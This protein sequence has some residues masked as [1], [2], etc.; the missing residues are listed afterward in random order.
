MKLDITKNSEVK[1]IWM[2]SDTHLG[3]RS[4]SKE[5]LGLVENYFFNFFI[6]LVKREYKVGDILIHCGDVFDSRHSINLFVQDLGIRI[7]EE[8]SSIFPFIYVIVGN[9][10]IAMKQ[11]N[12][13]SSVD[14]LKYI[15]GV[16]IL[17]N[18]EE[19]VFGNTRCLL[20]PWRRDQQHELETVEKFPN[21]KYVFCHSEVSGLQMSSNPKNVVEHGNSV[22]LYKKYK[23]VFS[24]HIHYHQR[25]SNF[26]LVGNPY[27]MTRSDAYNRKGIY[28]L[29]LETE[30]LDFFENNYSPK[31]LKVNF[32]NIQEIA[33][34]AFRDKIK[35]NFIDLYISS[36]AITKY[37]ISSFLLLLDGYCNRIEP[38][39]YENDEEMEIL[40]SEKDIIEN[41]QNF[42]ILTISKKYIEGTSHS[43]DLKDKLWKSV[44]EVFYKVNNEE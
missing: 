40:L 16:F 38:H 33:L 30:K 29:D 25:K 13:I 39:V 32:N 9:H 28:R 1:R 17:K 14:C 4:N 6:P 7:F 20:M 21:S 22:D 34:D 36:D 44:K 12:E 42:D 8:L 41:Y 26:L 37:N 43:D 27:E 5:W 11:S 24:G 10:D 35:N 23:M 18:E 31:F 2:I 19:K 3:M 15:P